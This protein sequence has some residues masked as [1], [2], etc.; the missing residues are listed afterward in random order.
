[1]GDAVPINNS[2]SHSV[3][4]LWR[5]RVYIN[6]RNGKRPW[7]I[8]NHRGT[9]GT[10][11][12]SFYADNVQDSRALASLKWRWSGIAGVSGIVIAQNRLPILTGIRQIDA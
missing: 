12:R 3:T 7:N 10:G 9:Y 4:P 2:Q 5:E 1:V 11:S 8:Q 6:G